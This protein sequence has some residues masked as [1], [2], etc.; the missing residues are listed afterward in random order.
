MGDYI[1]I[2]YIVDV[3]QKKDFFNVHNK[4]KINKE[5]GNKNIF[6]EPLLR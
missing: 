4:K 1:T 5:L 3:R 2:L 6:T